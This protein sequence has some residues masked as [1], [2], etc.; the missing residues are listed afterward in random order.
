M[1]EKKVI[2]SYEVSAAGFR[3]GITIAETEEFVRSYSVRIPE[4]GPATLSILK[5]VREEMIKQSAIKTHEILDPRITEILQQKFREQAGALIEKYLPGFG[6]KEK[7]QLTGYL[8]N[9][10]LGLGDI[11]ILL[12]D[13]K[14]EEVVI[15]N[16]RE[17]IWVYHKRWGWLKTDIMVESEEKILDYSNLVGRRVGRQ[18]TTLNPLM[19]AHMISGD[20]VNAT[21]FPIST[22]GNTLSVR[23]FA[24]KPWT[25]TDMIKINTLNTEVSALLWMAI[26]YE[27][28]ILVGGGTGT[29]KT[30]M[31]NAL[32]PFVQPN[33]RI[34]SIEDTR[35]LNLPDYL[36]WVPMTTREAN[37]EGKGEI[38]MLDLMVNALRMRPDRMV[39]GEIRRTREAE[40]LFEAMNTGHSV[41]S[42]L[43]ADRAEQ[44]KRRL[45]TQP[46]AVPES[47]IPALHLVIVQYRQ[48]RLGIRRTWEV[49]EVI[50]V[51][52]TAEKAGAE[53]RMLYRWKPREDRIDKDKESVR[54]MTEL[55]ILTGMT[56]REIL[57]DM[58]DK[59]E[60][61]NWMVKRDISDINDV[62]RLMA[63]YYRD[64]E[65]V[66]ELAK[67]DKPFG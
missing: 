26:Q 38:S 48:R 61:L 32:M 57:S 25:I 34:I 39:V 58:E 24:R 51:G 49:A 63:M 21:I 54:V 67:K 36:H 47:V 11:E 50:P 55:E 37:P 22:K 17:P 7:D 13:D 16:S 30:S 12:A 20:R 59:K 44:V 2:E 41:Y 66:L 4:I 14:L 62:G 3:A 29:G 23:K 8:I 35:E 65:L 46:I 56:E 15:N 64:S 28:S 6:K 1:V 33:Q 9:E 10:M 42:T 43:H 60:V 45:T 19:D 40:V 27:L 5:Q 31:L 52:E 18:I 53:F